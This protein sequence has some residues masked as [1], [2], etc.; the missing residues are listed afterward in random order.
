MNT[1]IALIN[2]LPYSISVLN[3]TALLVSF[4]NIIDVSVNEKVLTLHESF[5]QNPFPGL[6]ETVPAYS[7]LAV[8][9]DPLSI[10]DKRTGLP[11]AADFVQSIIRERLGAITAIGTADKKK[12]VTIPLY[13][14]GEDLGL[15]AGQKNLSVEEV[16]AFHHSVTYRIFM[17]GFLPGFP[18]MGPVDER[19]ATARRSTPRAKVKAGT[20]GIAGLQTGIYPLDSPGGWQLIGQTPL[21]IF[22]KDK[23]PAC[24]LEAGHEVKF[25]PISKEEFE[26]QNEYP[27]S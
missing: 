10:K 23:A 19:I 11:C 14:N 5:K 17:I 15:I 12:I 3:E 27:N 26:Q 22:D 25:I 21:R 8:F 9:Y 7:S 1:K 6:V 24:L 4:G 13:Y 2:S 18:Y 20:V 16:I